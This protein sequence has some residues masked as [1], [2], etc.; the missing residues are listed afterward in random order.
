MALQGISRNLG[1]GVFSTAAACIPAMRT[2]HYLFS[3][4]D[5]PQLSTAKPHISPWRWGPA[6][7]S[8]TVPPSG[9]SVWWTTRLS[10][11]QDFLLK[12]QQMR[13]KRRYLVTG[14]LCKPSYLRPHS[15]RGFAGLVPSEHP[16]PPRLP[17]PCGCANCQ[18]VGTLGPK[19][20]KRL[21]PA[22]GG[23]VQHSQRV[24]LARAADIIV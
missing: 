1:T 12:R 24:P 14:P 7:A 17:R 16:K 23:R 4:L 19:S 10:S 2:T 18:A 8:A 3:C 9:D 15:P 20:R 13:P 5:P 22:A 6:G 21:R 11:Q